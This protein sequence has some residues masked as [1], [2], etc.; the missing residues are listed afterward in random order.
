MNITKFSYSIFLKKNNNLNKSIIKKILG[1]KEEY[2]YDREKK[3]GITP[4]S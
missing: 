1:D 3:G 2:T 4:A